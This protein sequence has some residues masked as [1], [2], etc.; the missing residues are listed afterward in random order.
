MAK[1]HQ[2][3]LLKSLLIL[4]IG[5]YLF[6]QACDQTEAPE[7]MPDPCENTSYTYTEDVK[8]IF[9]RNC[10]SSSCHAGN[11]SL[12]DYSNYEGVYN[13]RF[14]LKSG[15]K[16][17]LSQL[18]GGRASLTEEEEDIILCWIETGAPE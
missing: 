6:I 13:D 16:Q 17:G 4:I 18:I 7:P 14:K 11:N 8:I 15:I 5:S 1:H 3:S 2:T 10:A 9:D 12:Q